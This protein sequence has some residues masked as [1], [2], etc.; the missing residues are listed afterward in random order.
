[1]V[2]GTQV[3]VKIQ[4]PGIEEEMRGDLLLMRDLAYLAA[5]RT[6]WGRI[7]AVEELVQ[8]FGDQLQ[9]QLNYT[10]EGHHTDR[11]RRMMHDIPRM[12]VPEVVWEYSTRRLLTTEYVQGIKL[13]DFATIDVERMDRRDLAATFVEIMAT[14]ALSYGFYHADPHPGNLMTTTDGVI[15]FMDF[16]MVGYLDEDLKTQLLDLVLAIVQNDLDSIVY[17]LLDIGV[18]TRHIDRA[19]LRTDIQK[20]LRKYY[21]VPLSELE[22]GDAI[23]EM[24]SLATKH[25]VRLPADLTL[26]VKV[27]LIVEG[28]STQLDPEMSIVDVAKPFAFRIQQERFSPRYFLK[29]ASRE[30]RG[31]QRLMTGLPARLDRL[32]GAFES[33]EVGIRVEVVQI[34]R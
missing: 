6:E 5:R 25:Q 21:E 22:V 23:S 10:V 31:I 3:V 4:R 14:Q 17:A 1:L 30:I 32:L 34:E 8:E 13:D 20:V 24:L 9:Q 27:A 19:Q 33:G 15:V 29:E 28:L 2:D 11:F 16:G 7:Y 12:Y 18:V 26:L